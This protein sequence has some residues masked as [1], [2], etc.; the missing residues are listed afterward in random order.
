MLNRIKTLLLS[1]NCLYSWK[2]SYLPVFAMAS[3]PIELRV[4]T[5]K[6]ILSE[7]IYFLESKIIQIWK[8]PYGIVVSNNILK[9]LVFKFVY[10][11]NHSI[12]NARFDL[13]FWIAAVNICPFATYVGWIMVKTYIPT[14]FPSPYNNIF[15][16]TT[17]N[18]FIDW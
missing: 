13:S 6:R 7:Q 8:L 12:I 2:T 9:I 14:N 16:T 1:R 4:M 18:I 17:E 3:K 5:R 11:I 10:F 15:L